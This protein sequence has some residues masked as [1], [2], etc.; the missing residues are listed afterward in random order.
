MIIED[1]LTIREVVA[2]AASVPVA[3]IHRMKTRRPD[4]VSNAWSV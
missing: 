2:T 3:R 4:A 1:K